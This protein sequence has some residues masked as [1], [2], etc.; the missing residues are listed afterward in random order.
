MKEIKLPFYVRLAFIL[1]IILTGGFLC[2]IAAPLVVPLLFSFLF[3]VLLLPVANS[4]RASQ[5]YQE[6]LLLLLLFCYY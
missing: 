3:A 4:L 1:I 5:N 6:V 2:I